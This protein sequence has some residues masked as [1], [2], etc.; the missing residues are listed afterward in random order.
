MQSWTLTVTLAGL[1]MLGAF[2]IDTFLPS[3]PAIADQFSVSMAV[4]QLALSAY[5]LA[6]SFMS[7][8]YGTLSDSFGRRPVILASLLL[9]TA[10]SIGAAFAPSFGWLLTFRVLQGLSAGGGRVIGQAIIRDRFSGAAAQRLMSHVTLVF[11]LAPA[12]APVLG[13]YLHVAFGWRSVFVFMTVLGLA[14]LAACLRFLPE[15]LPPASRIRFHPVTLAGNY[16]SAL[17][18]PQFVARTLAV[19]LGFGGLGLYIASAPSFIIKILHLPETAF[20]WLFLPMIGG[21]M[22]GSAF[23]ARLAHRVRP[24]AVLR[25]GFAC[26][27]LAAGANLVYNGFFVA[28]VP[29][30]VLPIMLYTFGLGLTMPVMSLMTLDLFPKVRGMAASLVS[31][32]QMLIFSLVSGVIAPMLFDSAV[33]LAEG[34]AVVFVLAMVCWGIGARSGK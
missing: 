26:M 14:L 18:H 22:I 3:F 1:A 28:A 15:S 32:V 2:A 29:W 17:R 10:A 25:I 23:S 8:F 20:A 30:A 12:I 33:K 9:F 4:V 19:G 24:P 16:W 21:M 31:F 6:F 11:G 27:G 13:G 34:M 7:L 5:L